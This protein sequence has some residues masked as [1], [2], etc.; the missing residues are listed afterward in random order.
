MMSSQSVSPGEGA[1]LALTGIALSLLL[2]NHRKA[3]ATKLVAVLRAP[4]DCHYVIGREGR[5]WW[6][7]H[8]PELGDQGLT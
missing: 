5:R 8:W 7:H 2:R 4:V 3:L 6:V 1:E